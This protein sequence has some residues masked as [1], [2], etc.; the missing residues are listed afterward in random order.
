MMS[1]ELVV[2]NASTELLMRVGGANNQRLK[3][4]QCAFGALFERTYLF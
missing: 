4:Y 3:P 2:G 1:L